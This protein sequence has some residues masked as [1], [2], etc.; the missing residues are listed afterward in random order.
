MMFRS[1]AKKILLGK[2]TYYK[3]FLR[4]QI[5]EKSVIAS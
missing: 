3:D 4:Q 5:K 1:F 2:S